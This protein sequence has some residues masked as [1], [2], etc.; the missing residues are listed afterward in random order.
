MACEGTNL[1]H[2]IVERNIDSGRRARCAVHPR[3]H[4]FSINVRV[5]GRC[6][7]W[8][9]S[10]RASTGIFVLRYGKFCIQQVPAGIINATRERTGPRSDPKLRF[11]NGPVN[12]VGFET[13]QLCGIPPHQAEEILQFSSIDDRVSPSSTSVTL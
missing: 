10:D 5:V 1:K 2:S 7:F 9:W 11:Q 12:F 3:P 4:C 8:M 6:P 13:R